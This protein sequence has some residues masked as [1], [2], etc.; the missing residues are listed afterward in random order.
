MQGA[1]P[2]AS[3]GLNP[4]GAG[5]RG[6]PLARR[7]ACPL[8]RLLPPAFSLLS[9]PLSPRPP[10]PAGKGVTKSLFRRG[11]RPRHPCTEPLAALTD[12]AKQAPAGGLSSSPPADPAF[13]LLSCPHP[14]ALPG[15]G[16]SGSCRPRRILTPGNPRRRRLKSMPRHLRP[17]IYIDE[18]SW[19]FGGFFQEAPNVSSLPRSPAGDVLRRPLYNR[20]AV[21]YNICKD[22]A[23]G[24]Q[25][26]EG[27]ADAQPSGGY[28]SVPVF[29]QQQ[30]VLHV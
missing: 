5:S 27:S 15:G 22:I 14:P 24:R 8:C 30:A 23:A 7:G 4:S 17:I 20:C 21:C 13:S 29:R 11:L 25:R 9:C 26:G 1:P 28:Q 10:S 18:S 6:E 16:L 12:L 3:L 19:G 2:L